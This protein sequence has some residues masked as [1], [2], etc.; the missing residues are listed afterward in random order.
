MRIF[1][2]FESSEKKQKLTHLKAVCALAIADG[3]VHEKE[4]QYLLTTVKKLGLEKK[5]LDR[6]IKR[7]NSISFRFPTKIEDKLLLLNDLIQIMLI[8]N[9]IDDIEVE[10]CEVISK[11]LGINVPIR[12][13]LKKMAQE[14]KSQDAKNTI[15][16]YLSKK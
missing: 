10:L 13:L 2:L 1:E 5:D 15:T 12:D 16:K 9:H 4:S 3:E 14:S 8:D 6:L 11:S 7:P